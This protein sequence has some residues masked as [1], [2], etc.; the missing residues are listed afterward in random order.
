MKESSEKKDQQIKELFDK[1]YLEEETK[2]IFR[3]L[4]QQGAL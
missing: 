2:W 4:K 1:D 3:R